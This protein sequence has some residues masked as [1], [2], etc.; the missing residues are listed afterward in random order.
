MTQIHF[1][2]KL[3]CLIFLLFLCVSKS[4]AQEEQVVE[5]QAFTHQIGVD[6]VSFLRGEQGL[7]LMYKQAISGNAGIFKQHQTALRIGGGFYT[8]NSNQNNFLSIDADTVYRQYFSSNSKVQFIKFGV[9]NQIN[10]KK[11]RF[12][13]GADA[14]FRYWNSDGLS[15][16][17]KQFSTTTIVLDETKFKTQARAIDV[18][19]LAGISYFIIPRLSVGL[20]ANFSAGREFSNTSVTD[21]NG[22][23]SS[24]TNGNFDFDIQTWRLLLLSFHFGQPKQ[25]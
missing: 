4:H 13:Y 23:S 21:S 15:Q 20:E 18:S 10:R 1:L 9:E 16:T 24:F 12:H 19:F 7:S 6:F 14:G 2:H 5:K 11:W 8:D 25:K 3:A 22:V 17:R